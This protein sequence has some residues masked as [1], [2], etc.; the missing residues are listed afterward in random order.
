MST[1]AKIASALASVGVLALGWQVGTANG[2]TLA[3]TTPT[4]KTTTTGNTTT[5]TSAASTT[6]TSTSASGLKDGTFTGTAATNRYG[7]VTVT[8]TVASGKITNV[9]AATSAADS[10][11]Q[12]INT[13]AVP[14]LKSEVLAA[15]SADI[16]TVSG[17]TYTS[18]SYITSLQSALDKAAA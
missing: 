18:Q 15:Q 14:T 13:R 5:T 11:S 9:T 12:Q 6:T 16:S 2:Q 7:G 3:T 4:T 17:A 8:V 1:R 10:K